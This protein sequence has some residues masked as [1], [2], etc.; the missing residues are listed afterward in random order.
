MSLRA[1]A[2]IRIRFHVLT[3]TAY[4][5]LSSIPKYGGGN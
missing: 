5:A 1:K 3:E 4:A 2:W